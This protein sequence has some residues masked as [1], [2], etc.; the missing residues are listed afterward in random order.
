MKGVYIA[1]WMVLM[2]LC[3]LLSVYGQITVSGTVINAENGQKLEYAEVFVTELNKGVVTGKNGRFVLRNLQEGSMTLVVNH[4]GFEPAIIQLE[5][6]RDTTIL[7]RLKQSVLK[8]PEVVVSAGVSTQHEN[9]ITIEVMHAS[10]IFDASGGNVMAALKQV[11]GV[12]LISRGNAISQPVIRGMTGNNIAVL[13]DGIPLENYQ[14]SVNH[15]FMV[16]APGIKKVEVIKGPASLLYGSGAMG[17]AVNF[18]THGVVYNDTVY[19]DVYTQLLTNGFGFIS[20]GNISASKGRFFVNAAAETK[21]VSDFYDA[22]GQRVYNTAFSGKTFVVTA[23]S[24]S[25]KNR[26]SVLFRYMKPEFGL[27]VPQLD[28]A[29]MKMQMHPSV[30]YQD[31]TD[32]MLMITD[33]YTLGNSELEIKLAQQVNNR[34]LHTSRNMPVFTPIDMTLNTSVGKV[35]FTHNF[36][37]LLEL[38]TGMDAMFQTNKNNGAPEH[39]IPDAQV[40][41][42]ATFVVGKFFA[43]EKLIFQFGGRYD[44]KNIMT[45]P[46]SN[47]IAV[48]NDYANIT[49]S[50]GFTYQWAGQVLLRVNVASGF[51]T[52]SLPEL[53]QNGIHGDRYEKGNVDLVPQSNYEADVGLHFHTERFYMDVSGFVNRVE[54]YIYLTPSNDTL[55]GLP[56]Y[57]YVQND[58]L[59]YGTEVSFMTLL[60]KEWKAGVDFSYLR[61][62]KSDGSDLPMIQQPEIKGTITYQHEGKIKRRDCFYSLMIQPVYALADTHHAYYELPGMAYF[63][64]DITLSGTV[65]FESTKLKIGVTVKNLWNS[66]YYDKLSLLSNYGF[67]MPGRSI[68]CWLKFDF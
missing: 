12:S 66:V 67:Y 27:Y 16:D 57:Y 54:K 48:D 29:S 40:A 4:I 6:Y 18:I 20:G 2:Y 45:L 44:W 19:G 17:G 31:L 8:I 56:V 38:K 28:T 68:T 22:T 39:L 32:K 43:G 23:G 33:N 11:Q 3:S 25:K 52:P 14:F 42:M 35:I 10:Q 9:A 59:L 34:K 13:I 60:Y 49:G 46:D 51:R 24:V 55:A 63:N 15:P 41:N 47:E 65:R 61:G 58:A 30:W 7:V 53:T 37:H 62:I 5:S 50:A 26:A 64:T 36:N 1:L 21:A